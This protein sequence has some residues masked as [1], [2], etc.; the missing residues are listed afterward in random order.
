MLLPTLREPGNVKIIGAAVAAVIGTPSA[1]FGRERA[2]LAAAVA[3]YRGKS[4]I[5]EIGKAF[6]LFSDLRLL[7]TMRVAK[8]GAM[9]YARNFH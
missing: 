1:R 9:P 2:R 7:E 5:R 8:R 4:A 3:T 6:G